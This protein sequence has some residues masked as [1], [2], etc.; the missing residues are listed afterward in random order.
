MRDGLRKLALPAVLVLGLGGAATLVEAVRDP[1]PELQA[2]Q[3]ADPARDGAGAL[4]GAFRAASAAAMPAVVHVKVEIGGRGQRDGDLF[5]PRGPQ[6]GS[7]SG[8]IVSPDGHVITNN[9]VVEG[10][11]R[12]TVVLNDRREF[13]ARVVG[14]DP[15]TDVAV[16]KI[17]GRGLPTLAL[18]NADELQVG[19]WVLALGYPLDLGQTTTA[20]IVSAKGRDLGI[21]AQNAAA[22]APL[23]HF[24]QTDAAINRGNSGGPLVDL[25]GR[26]VGVNSAIASPTGFYS[27]Y[28]FAVPINL[29]RRV[30]DDLIRDGEVHRPMLGVEIRDAGPADAEVFGLASPSGVVVASEPKAGARDAGLRLGDVI[31]GL[32]GRPVRDGGDLRETLMR[33]RPGDRVPVEVV[34]YGKRERMTVR[35]D[36]MD[37]R[38][39]AQPALQRAD[40]GGGT[41]ARIG[42]VAAEVT[43][44]QARRLGL[45]G[46]GGVVVA[47]VDP[48]GPAAGNLPRGVVV[49]R[50][51]GR[52]IGSAADLETAAAAVRPGGVVSIVAR[53]DDGSR[54]IVNYRAKS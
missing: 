19:D 20:G 1:L 2:Q 9:H 32:D 44:A 49:E 12:V 33:R 38:P 43:P 18:G 6:A 5:G 30:A 25:R 35:L 13:D 47:G 4:A 50:F 54:I 31:V 16:L 41:A 8:F 15:N 28:G 27:G 45:E 23:E 48:M 52:A 26:V 51:N 36:E 21:T 46:A 14:R 3:A 7:G 17:D 39:V 40:A 22:T 29:A 10:A 34:R 42:F 24:I 11:T 53:R 37:T